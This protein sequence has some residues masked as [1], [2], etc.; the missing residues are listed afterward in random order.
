MIIDDLATDLISDQIY[1]PTSS[2]SIPIQPLKPVQ[3]SLHEPFNLPSIPS[4]LSD[5]LKMIRDDGLHRE[6]GDFDDHLED[7]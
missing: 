7:V 4:L 5:A 1:H 3:G 6:L 2:K